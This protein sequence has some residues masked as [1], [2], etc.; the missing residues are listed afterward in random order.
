MKRWESMT[1]VAGTMLF[2]GSWVLVGNIVLNGVGAA[3][4]LLPP[5]LFVIRFVE[6]KF[7]RGAGAH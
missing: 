7:A 1:M 2:F 5:V 4:I 3:L 6:G